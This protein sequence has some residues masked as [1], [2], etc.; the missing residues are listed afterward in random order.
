MEESRPSVSIVG[1][2]ESRKR[3]DMAKA[4]DERSNGSNDLFGALKVF[5]FLN[6]DAS[7]S[8]DVNSS[9]PQPSVEPKATS[10]SR[11]DL[12][13]AI[14]E[15]EED[16]DEEVRRASSIALAISSSS[17]LTPQEALQLVGQDKRQ[18]KLVEQAKKKKQQPPA[19]VANVNNSLQSILNQGLQT[20]S[21]L[22]ASFAPP[23]STPSESLTAPDLANNQNQNI[24]IIHVS[25]HKIHPANQDLIAQKGHQLKN[26]SPP[27]SN[28]RKPTNSSSKVT[29]PRKHH[30]VS[31]PSRHRN[32]QQSLF[33]PL[34]EKNH[35]LLSNHTFFRTP[36]N[37][38]ITA[39]NAVTTTKSALE[40]IV[41][42]RRNGFGKLST[43]HAW[44]RR[45][46]ALKGSK[47]IYYPISEEEEE[48][49]VNND[50]DHQQ[51]I[52][53][54]ISSSP[55]S[56]SSTT[57]NYTSKQKKSRSHPDLQVPHLKCHLVFHD[58]KMISMI[59]PHFQMGV[60][61]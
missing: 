45:K 38:P 4:K 9:T 56:S 54:K 60:G 20:T 7:K 44:E 51:D 31:P 47:L 17:Q 39:S 13:S 28:T 40:A 12:S 30:S 53:P 61:Q 11:S 25:T 8:N 10:K 57:S 32:S 2:S 26:S 6:D 21:T 41:W 27:P 16:E 59:L 14:K 33:P 52:D 36:T 42:K 46:L 3:R 22:T 5:Q 18:T 29:P 19:W 43:R 55:T 15:G 1:P 24:P 23:N 58:K 50:Q 35:F 37:H 34:S 48:Q 49:I